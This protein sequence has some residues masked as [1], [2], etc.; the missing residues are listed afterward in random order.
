MYL[1][2]SRQNNKR[3][4]ASELSYPVLDSTSWTSD[5][6]SRLEG[7]Q[8]GGSRED[9]RLH[10]KFTGEVKRRYWGF[11]DLFGK[12]WRVPGVLKGGPR[13]FQGVV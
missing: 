4:C 3:G 13:V 8:H 12:F 11:R 10:N 1:H 9:Q 7:I 6:N 5:K 2:I